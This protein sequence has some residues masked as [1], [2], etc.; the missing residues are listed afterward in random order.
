MFTWLSSS[1]GTWPKF[2]VRPVLQWAAIRRVRVG[3][4]DPPAR[5]SRGRSRRAARR[6]SAETPT[7][8]AVCARPT[9][10]TLGDVQGVVH[11]IH[12]S[13]GGVPKRP[14][15][16]AEIGLRGVAGD[17]QANRK[18]HG[19]PWQALCLWSLEVI[20]E[21]R[22]EGHP[23]EPGFAGE[24]LTIRG[25][26]WSALVPGLRLRIGPSV[27]AEVTAYAIPCKHNGP[28]FR[29]GDFL[30]MSNDRHPGSSRIYTSVEAGGRVV[31]GDPVVVLDR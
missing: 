17:R 2:G 16:V 4:E 8:P 26:D 3:V 18:H 7:L 10:G 5:R 28:W 30:R 24:N 14:I 29:D 19:A 22:A 25:L 9:S 13:D 6:P 31:P 23:I 21:L 12:V 15:D 1:S 27:L 11:A 20:E